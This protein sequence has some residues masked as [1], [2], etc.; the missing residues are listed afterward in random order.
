MQQDFPSDGGLPWPWKGATNFSSRLLSSDSIPD[1]NPDRYHDG[2]RGRHCSNSNRGT[3]VDQ[4]L[5]GELKMSGEVVKYN[6]PDKLHCKEGWRQKVGESAMPEA[7][8]VDVEM[9]GKPR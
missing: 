1:S 5:N 9:M 8:G 4:S 7:P 6:V 3:G 2:L